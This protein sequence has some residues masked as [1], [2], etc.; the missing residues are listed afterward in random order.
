MNMQ[1]LDLQLAQHLHKEYQ[2]VC[3]AMHQRNKRQC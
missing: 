1:V 3:S 2:L